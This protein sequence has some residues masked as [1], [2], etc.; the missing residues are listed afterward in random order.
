MK[1]RREIFG[2]LVVGGLGMCASSLFAAP[3]K[4]ATRQRVMS[5]EGKFG[6]KLGVA[7]LD[8][9]TGH[10]FTSRGDERFPFCSVGKFAGVA[11]L[12]ARVD[13]GEE[14]LSRLIAYTKHDLVAHSPVTELHLATGM[15]VGALC[16][17]SIKLSDN[18]AHNL[19]LDS[20][21]GPSAVTQF[22]RSMGDRITR[23]DRREPELNSVEAGDL[24]DT[25]SPRA[26]ALFMQRVLMGNVLSPTSRTQLLDLLIGTKT[27]D[28]RLR[29]ATPLGW[30]VGDKTGTGPRNATNDI[31]IVLP[32]GRPPIMIAAFYLESTASLEDREA[33]LAEVGR[34]AVTG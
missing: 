14:V 34:L 28:K 1:T 32:P 26:I 30:Q 15:T 13:Q 33:V 2:N 23:V 4:S 12:L 7:I 16:A 5:I 8:T 27:G 20:V 25:T 10:M 6:G 17:A 19:I 9:G 11:A 29:A 31:A 18:S 21:G 24:R 3:K 22:H